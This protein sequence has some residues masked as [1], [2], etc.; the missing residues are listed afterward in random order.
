MAQQDTS[1]TPAG[2]AADAGQRQFAIQRIYVKDLSFEAPSSPEVF[3]RDWK[4]EVNMNLG[5]QSRSLDASHHE[6]TLTATVTV[7]SGGTTAFLVEVKQAGIFV[8]SGFPPADVAPVLGSYCPN[9]LFPYLREVVSD[10]VTRGGFPQFL[11]APVNFD[12]AYAQAVRQQ[13]SG[14]SA[15]APA[16]AEAQAQN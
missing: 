1:G 16:P 13:Q 7:S 12:A 5:T 3:L 10:L 2:G 4:P 6:V 8:L 15:P 9:I 14:Q 11:M